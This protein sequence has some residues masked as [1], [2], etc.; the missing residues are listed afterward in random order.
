[1]CATFESHF[2]PFIQSQSTWDWALIHVLSVLQFVDAWVVVVVSRAE[3][4]V[5]G[6]DAVGVVVVPVGEN[7]QVHKLVQAQTR[8]RDVVDCG[9]KPCHLHLPGKI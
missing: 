1:M 4:D 3:H 6:P 2:G 9:D 8:A 5:E 7:R